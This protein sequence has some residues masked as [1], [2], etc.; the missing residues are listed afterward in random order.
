MLVGFDVPPTY[1][2]DKCYIRFTLPKKKPG[3]GGYEWT[4]NGSGK[5]DVW[6]LDGIIQLGSSPPAVPRSLNSFY[7]QLNRPC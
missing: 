2:G 5:L 3:Q 6:Y 4:V 1:G 7:I